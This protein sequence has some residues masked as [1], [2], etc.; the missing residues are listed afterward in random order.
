MSQKYK[1]TGGR[2]LG[3]RLVLRKINGIESNEIAQTL[4]IKK[5]KNNNDNETEVH[6]WWDILQRLGK[7]DCRV[8]E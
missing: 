7:G 4:A 5:K 2:F 3:Q 1:S 8:T 6:L